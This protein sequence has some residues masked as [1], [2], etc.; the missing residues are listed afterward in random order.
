MLRAESHSLWSQGKLDRI[1]W[2]ISQRKS[3]I[4]VFGNKSELQGLEVKR[5]NQQSSC[6]NTNAVLRGI[7]RKIMQEREKQWTQT[8]WRWVRWTWEAAWHIHNNIFLNVA[9]SLVGEMRISSVFYIDATCQRIHAELF[10]HSKLPF[11]CVQVNPRTAVINVYEY[12]MSGRP[13]QNSPLQDSLIVSNYQNMLA[14]VSLLKRSVQNCECC[15]QTR[16][17]ICLS[18]TDAELSWQFT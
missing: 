6:S 11:R 10:I 7:K 4:S 16:T 5:P 9:G 1:F 14:Q 3:L 18:S 2:H 12:C 15:I 8:S 17:K 13:F